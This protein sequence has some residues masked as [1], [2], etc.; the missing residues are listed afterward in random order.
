[1]TPTERAA[2][3]AAA[4]KATKG[5]WYVNSKFSKKNFR[6]ETRPSMAICQTFGNSCGDEEDAAYI[7]LANPAAILSLIAENERLQEFRE[8]ALGMPS[9]VPL[10]PQEEAYWAQRGE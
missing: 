8:A 5:T 6:V 2:L 7:A 4:E 1:M 9:R 3:K 10:T